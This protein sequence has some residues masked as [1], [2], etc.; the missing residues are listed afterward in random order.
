MFDGN[1]RR[2]GKIAKVGKFALVFYIGL[3]CIAGIFSIVFIWSLFKGPTNNSEIEWN[4]SHYYS[5]NEY[6][7]EFY[8]AKIVERSDNAIKIDTDIS[9]SFWYRCGKGSGYAKVCEYAETKTGDGFKYFGALLYSVNK[10]RID[11]LAKK[12]GGEILGKVDG[13]RNNYSFADDA[14]RVN[15]VKAVMSIKM[16]APAKYVCEKHVED[17]DSSRYKC[18][19]VSPVFIDGLDLFAL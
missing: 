7:R 15:F 6:I 2:F 11:E 3:A 13:G 9:W 10:N 12:Y 4:L 8:G 16:I 17:G 14:N 18:D 5:P 1:K 19:E